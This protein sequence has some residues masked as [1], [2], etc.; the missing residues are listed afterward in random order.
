M[1]QDNG[2]P[3]DQ[4]APHDDAPMDQTHLYR[5]RRLIIRTENFYGRQMHDPIQR[6]NVERFLER[7][8]QKIEAIPGCL[9]A[10]MNLFN[11]SKLVD[12]LTNLSDLAK[13]IKD[14]IYDTDVLVDEMKMEVKSSTLAIEEEDKNIIEKLM[15]HIIEKL[16]IRISVTAKDIVSFL[17]D[18][19]KSLK[20]VIQVR[21]ASTN[22]LFSK[23]DPLKNS[24]FLRRLDKHPQF[25]SSLQNILSID[26]LAGEFCK[27]DTDTAWYTELSGLTQKRKKKKKKMKRYVF[28]T[29]IFR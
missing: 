8:S 4:R 5:I 11:Q 27:L 13:Q 24:R 20:F 29:V 14:K 3:T 7:F 2:A 6:R 18:N 21:I 17:D 1:E 10:I 23:P 9:E 12:M 15:I 25:Q 19:K 22:S 28:A 16:H 26:S